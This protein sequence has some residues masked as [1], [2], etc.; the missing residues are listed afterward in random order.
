MK[1]SMTGL[2]LAMQFIRDVATMFF[3]KNG[4]NQAS[5]CFLISYFSHDKYS[6]NTINDKSVVGVLGT[7]TRAGRR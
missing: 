3:L 5:F 6:T 4:P 7:R 2:F 1:P